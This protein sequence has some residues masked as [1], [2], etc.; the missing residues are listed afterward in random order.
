M[1]RRAASITPGHVWNQQF[2]EDTRF[3]TVS[4]WESVEALREFV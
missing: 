4:V 3:M 2:T 1:V